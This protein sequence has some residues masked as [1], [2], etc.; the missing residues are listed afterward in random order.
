MTRHHLK[1]LLTCILLIG[2]NLQILAQDVF[3]TQF[4]LAPLPNSIGLIGLKNQKQIS[5][6]FRNQQVGNRNAYTT[7][8]V[9]AVLPFLNKRTGKKPLTLGLSFLNDAVGDN[10][11]LQSNGFSLTAAYH[12]EFAPNAQARRKVLSLAANGGYFQRNLSTDAL[13][14]GSQWNGDIFDASL[15]IGEPLE[16]LNDNRSFPLFSAGIAFYEV[17]ACGEAIYYISANAEHLNQPDISFFSTPTNLSMRLTAAAGF[18]LQAGLLE[19]QPN[20]RW[21]QVDNTRQIRLGNLL[22]YPLGNGKSKI[23]A[24][25]WYD[26]N[27]SLAFSVEYQHQNFFLGASYD[28]GAFDPITNLNAQTLELNLGIKFG[29]TCHQADTTLAPKEDE[30]IQDTIVSQSEDCRY[31]IARTLKKKKKIEIAR[32]TLE[33][34]CK[35]DNPPVPRNFRIFDSQIFFFYLSDDINQASEAKLQKIAAFLKTYSQVKVRIIGHTCKI[36]G[37]KNQELSESRAER[38]KRYLIEQGVAAEQLETEGRANREPILSDESEYGRV[39]NRRVEF[40]IL[41]KGSE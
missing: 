8:L 20:L 40:E 33:V 6:S 38:V 11:L 34:L 10:G 17:D 27:Q 24:G 2:L 35:E 3:F 19:F 26:L 30:L 23:G 29:K 22:Y 13:Q 5:Y 39:R 31:T 14:S 7:H 25:T 9:S 36:G 21:I 28:L 4:H 15:P 37:D 18:R 32:D 41:E 12:L 16:L 1:Y